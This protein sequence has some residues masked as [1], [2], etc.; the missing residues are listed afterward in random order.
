[1]LNLELVFVPA[2][3]RARSPRWAEDALRISPGCAPS[4]KTPPI[5]VSLQPSTWNF[6]SFPTVVCTPRAKEVT[7][8]A[9]LGS[10]PATLPL[11]VNI[12]VIWSPI[13]RPAKELMPSA[14]TSN[15][16]PPAA[17]TLLGEP[18]EGEAFSYMHVSRTSHT[19]STLFTGS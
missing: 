5:S 1:M 12:R 13:L 19:S 16:L 3:V 14:I 15:W 2:G 6:S 10:T 8:S 4:L 11:A 9:S 7:L 17:V 18:G